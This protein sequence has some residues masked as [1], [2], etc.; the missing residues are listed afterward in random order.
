MMRVNT[1][2]QQVREYPVNALEPVIEASDVSDRPIARF[3]LTARPPSE[4]AIVE[5][6]STHPEVAQA[7]EPARRAMNTGLRVFR[8]Q[9][10]YE[11][12]KDTCP[13]LAELLPPD[14]NLQKVRKLSEDA[15]IRSTRWSR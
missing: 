2:L 8:L 13:E 3:A 7:L 10:V 15:S 12:Q 14:V 1:R 9:K 5:F 4:A 6:Q 11:Q